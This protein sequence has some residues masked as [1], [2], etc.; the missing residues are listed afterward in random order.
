MLEELEDIW[1]AAPKISGDRVNL[2]AFVQIYRDIDDLFEDEDASALSHHKPIT[3]LIIRARGFFRR[4][5]EIGRQRLAGRETGDPKS[6]D[7]GFRTAGDH[8]VSCAVPDQTRGVADRMRA[9]RT[10][11][12][13]RMVRTAEAVFDRDLP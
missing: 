3:I 6:A 2:D 10:G 13:D 1:N 7:R 12:D 9:G 8:H 11:G 5:V 4:V